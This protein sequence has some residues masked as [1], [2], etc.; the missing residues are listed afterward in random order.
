MLVVV[1]RLLELSLNQ[2]MDVLVHSVGLWAEGESFLFE[3]FPLFGNVS[4]GIEKFWLRYTLFQWS[5]LHSAA[6][7]VSGEKKFEHI[8]PGVV[9]LHWLPVSHR[10]ILKL[11]LFVYKAFNG[12]WPQYLADLL[13]HQ[14]SSS[15]LCLNSRDLL[16]QPKSR[17]I[18]WKQGVG[19]VRPKGLELPSFKYTSF[20]HCLIV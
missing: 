1:L 15:T 13:H 5:R 3:L 9:H 14:K 18:L 10:F 8:T 6:R 4:N 11:L 17:T 19:R 12:L 16:I 2:L 20:Q 7:F